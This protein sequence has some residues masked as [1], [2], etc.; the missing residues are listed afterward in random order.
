MLCL[1]DLPTDLPVGLLHSQT[2]TSN[3]RMIFR[4]PSLVGEHGF[5]N[6]FGGHLLAPRRFQR[7]EKHRIGEHGSLP[8]QTSYRTVPY[9]DI[10]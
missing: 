4:T 8:P 6:E 1:E 10:Y 2:G 5:G 9:A 3:T 7:R